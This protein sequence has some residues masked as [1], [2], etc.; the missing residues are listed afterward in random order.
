MPKYT[1]EQIE[2]ILAGESWLGFSMDR[3]RELETSIKEYVD[4]G[5]G[6]MG[7]E[8]ASVFDELSDVSKNQIEYFT[9]KVYESDPAKH[10]YQVLDVGAGHGTRAVHLAAQDKVNLKAIELSDYFYARHLLELEKEGLLPFGCAMKADMC[11]MPFESAT[12]DAIYCNTALH[13]QV[14]LP[15]KN[16]GIEKIMSEF[17]RVLLKGGKLYLLTLY[18]D[19]THFRLQRFFQSLTEESMKRLASR[20]SFKIDEMKQIEGY[21][22]FG[23]KTRYLEVYLTKRNV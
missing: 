21:G 12:F 1:P 2:E 8:Y 9:S 4:D 13:H 23:P 14:Y 7:A 18:G 6:L 17:S 15:G 19:E 22:V 20:N 16:I 5:Y 10:R 3:L 11:D